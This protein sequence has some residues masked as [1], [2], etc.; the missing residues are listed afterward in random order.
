MPL[1]ASLALHWSL[2]QWELLLSCV[3]RTAFRPAAYD[4]PAVYI[5]SKK[6]EGRSSSH[7]G[8]VLPQTAQQ[9][10]Q[11]SIQQPV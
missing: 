10:C 2:L 9:L 4:Q 3:S 11:D 5:L 7:A 6:E 1:W 8:T